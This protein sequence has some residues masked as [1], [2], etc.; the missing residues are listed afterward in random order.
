[1]SPELNIEPEPEDVIA[2]TGTVGG[3]TLRA[4]VSGDGAN[5]PPNDFYPTPSH[6]TEALLKHERFSGSIW[7]PAC[8]DGSI[9]RVLEASGYED[10]YSS[11]LHQYGYGFTGVDFLGLDRPFLPLELPVGNIITNPPYS[12]AHR[13]AGRALDLTQSKVAMLLKLTFLESARRRPLF[14]RG[15]LARI[16]VFSNRITLHAN[17]VAGENSGMIC[18]AWFV[19]DKSHIGPPTINWI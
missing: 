12:L 11:D 17:G 9:S 8:G 1:M 18:F 19:W 14:E 5:R 10:V 15:M 13:F 3:R 16:H 6:A 4:S 7:E 2:L